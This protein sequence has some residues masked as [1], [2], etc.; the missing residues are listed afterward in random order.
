[1]C[2]ADFYLILRCTAC[3]YLRHMCTVIWMYKL[4]ADN[5]GRLKDRKSGTPDRMRIMSHSLS[6]TKGC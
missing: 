4:T 5:Q 1:M 6:T 2:T 3:V